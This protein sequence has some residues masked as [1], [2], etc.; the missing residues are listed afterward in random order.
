MSKHRRGLIEDLLS[1][2]RATSVNNPTYPNS[3]CTS[4]LS[5]SS[6][7]NFFNRTA[8]LIIKE[9]TMNIHQNSKLKISS[10][11]HFLTSK[12]TVWHSREKAKKISNQRA[13]LIAEHKYQL[14]TPKRKSITK[15]KVME[16]LS[17]HIY[18]YLQRWQL[19]S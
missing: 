16:T 2:H 8:T 5:P 7:E 17:L 6:P 14:S 13:L 3:F 10:L 4:T 18:E 1:H 11:R 9:L 15:S 19:A 12:E